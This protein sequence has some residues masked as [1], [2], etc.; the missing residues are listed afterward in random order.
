MLQIYAPLAG[1]L[2]VV[3]WLGVLSERVASQSR[4]IQNLETE[5]DKLKGE[6]GHGSERIV[7]L[8]VKVENVE[9]QGQ[10]ILRSLEGIQR[11]LANMIQRGMP[12]EFGVET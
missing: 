1:L 7:R 3:F 11:Q 2:C 6:D 5:V 9:T 8:E 4:K 12:R 10:S